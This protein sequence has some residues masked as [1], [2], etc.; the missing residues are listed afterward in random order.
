MICFVFIG[1]SSEV[2]SFRVCL[3]RTAAYE[4]PAHEPPVPR[5]GEPL[6]ILCAEQ[7]ISHCT[8]DKDKP[9]VKPLLSAAFALVFAIV[10]AADG[11]AQDRTPAGGYS[12]AAPNAI[13]PLTGKE[14][15]GRKWM[16]EQRIDNCKVPPD[17]QRG[18]PRSSECPHVPTG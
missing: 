5:C 14:R 4:K 18:R 9:A 11:L 17:K 6:P 13:D 15:L 7:V 8:T 3:R 10:G 12:T 16:D 1:H 2:S